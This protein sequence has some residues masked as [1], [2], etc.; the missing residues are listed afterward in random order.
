M[1]AELDR[2]WLRR[3]AADEPDTLEVREVGV[4]GRRR[5]EPDLLADLAHRGRVAV[6]VDVRD[7]ELPDLLLTRGEGY[8]GGH[9]VAS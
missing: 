5:G 2:A 7:E 1:A 8:L 9:G 3:V 4:H 6:V